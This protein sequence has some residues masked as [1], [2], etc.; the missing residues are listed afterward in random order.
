[1]IKMNTLNHLK[2]RHLDINRHRVFISDDD[3]CVTFP[4][5]N[6]SGSMVGYHRYRPFADKKKCNATDG[7]YYTFRKSYGHT[8]WGLESYYFNNGPIFLTEGI[9]DACRITERGYTALA[10]LSNNPPKDFKNFLSFLTRPIV[11][12]L[13]NDK[14]GDKLAKFGEYVEVVPEGDLGDS[15]DD[16]VTELLNKYT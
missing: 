1:M 2:E 7:R 13:D 3:S 11:A 14:A 4:L 6:F 8:P 9:F 12:V 16:Y 15:S 10:V 5:W